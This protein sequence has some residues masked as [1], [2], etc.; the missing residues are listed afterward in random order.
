MRSFL[1]WIRPPSP[2][3]I[4]SNLNFRRISPAEKVEEETFPDYLAARYYP[5]RIG[6]VFVS[7]YQVVGKLGYGVFSTVWLARDLKYRMPRFRVQCTA[8]W[9]S[10]QLT[11]LANTAMLP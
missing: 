11:Y 10:P 2:P 7:R 6:E 4:F 1:R 8:C 3:R 5:V 9:Q